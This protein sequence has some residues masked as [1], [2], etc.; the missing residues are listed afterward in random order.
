MEGDKNLNLPSN[1]NQESDDLLK[2][3]DDMLVS[4]MF[5]AL[6]R[7]GISHTDANNIVTEGYANFQK[8]LIRITADEAE[9]QGN[10]ETPKMPSIPLDEMV[11]RLRPYPGLLSLFIETLTPEEFEH[12]GEAQENLPNDNNS[13]SSK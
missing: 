12:L 2:A 8:E 4:E 13:S 1:P 3:R 5:F 7:F 9:N 11:E 10:N 6:R